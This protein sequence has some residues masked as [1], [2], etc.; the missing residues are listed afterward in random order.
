MTFIQKK[1]DICAKYNIKVE[2]VMIAMFQM[3]IMD[4][5]TL[6]QAFKPRYSI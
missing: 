2:R 5:K 1:R 6:K 4:I 3:I